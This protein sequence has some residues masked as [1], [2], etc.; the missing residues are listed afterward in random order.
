MSR[1]MDLSDIESAKQHLIAFENEVAQAC[2]RGEVKG[3]VHFAHGNEYQLIKIF[4][5]IKPEDYVVEDYAER[6]YSIDNLRK[7][8]LIVVS[9]ELHRSSLINRGVK[10]QDW[11]F[12]SYRSHYQALLKGMPPEVLRKE[13]MTGRS[14]HPLSQDHHFVT[15]AIVPGH[16]PQATGFA[17]GLKRKGIQDTYVWAFCGDM[18]AETGA[19]LE[20]STYAARHKLPI[21]FVIEDNGVSVDTPT[22]KVWGLEGHVQKSLPGLSMRYWYENKYPHQGVGRE[23]GF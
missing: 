23:V 22:Q 19:F 10:P 21:I 9:D 17:F 4:R 2:Q 15:S 6:T 3:P 16:I 7:N 18:A 20:S 1:N 5:G 8:G 13:I 12:A 14:M 11:I